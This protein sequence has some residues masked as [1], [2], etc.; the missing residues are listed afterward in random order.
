MVSDSSFSWLIN[1]PKNVLFRQDL[2]V[3]GKTYF[4]RNISTTSLKLTG[5][6]VH[7]EETIIKLKP[8]FTRLLVSAFIR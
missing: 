1:L 7:F 3:Q 2:E 5:T 8:G 4:T 6:I